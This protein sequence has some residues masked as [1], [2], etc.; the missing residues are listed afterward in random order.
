MNHLFVERSF[1][2]RIWKGVNGALL[3]CDDRCRLNYL[4]D[5]LQGWITSQGSTPS[6][7]IPVIVCWEIWKMRNLMFFEDLKKYVIPLVFKFLNI[8]KE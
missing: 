4:E 8:F 3:Q 5:S 2:L 6:K 1:T 7:E